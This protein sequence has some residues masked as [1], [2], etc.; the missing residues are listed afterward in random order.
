MAKLYE[1]LT[2]SPPLL[3]KS[4]ACDP[5]LFLHPVTDQQRISNVTTVLARLAAV[6]AVPPEG[7]VRRG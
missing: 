2:G 7:K 6:G 4:A 5:P 3:G 1:V